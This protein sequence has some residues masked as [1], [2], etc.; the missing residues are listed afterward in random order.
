LGMKA[1]WSWLALTLIGISS[2]S[3]GH[4]IHFEIALRRN[5]KRIGYT[6]EEGKQGGNIDSL[7]DLGLTPAMIAE[8]LDVFFCCAVG[9]LGYFGDVFEENA[10][11]RC[12]LSLVEVPLR[13]R[14][15]R[16]L[17]CSL[18]PQEVCM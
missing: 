11:S 1:E 15:H 7:C 18:N 5:A 14:L 6:I 13:N 12:E 2:G 10:L 17:V 16:F 3:L 8:D 4:G 9:G